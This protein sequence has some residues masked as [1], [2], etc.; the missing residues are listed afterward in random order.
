MSGKNHNLSATHL[1]GRNNSNFAVLVVMTALAFYVSYLLIR[2]FTPA[3]VWSVT[4][5]VVT[6]R[7]WQWLE[8]YVRWPNLRAG[9]AVGTVAVALLAPIVFLVYFSAGEISKTIDQWQG[10]EHSTFWQN[11]LGQN[12]RIEEAW[13]WISENFD[14]P[15]MAQQ[16]ARYLQG[17]AARIFSGL[18]YTAVQAFLTLF[19][20]YFLYRDEREVLSAVRRFSPMTSSETDQVLHRLRDTILATIYGSVVVALIQGLLGGLIFLVLGVPGAILWG[21]AM[22]LLAL[23]PYLG[24]F[25]V[26]MP[27]AVV[28]ALYGEWGKAGMLVAWG[29]CVIAMIDNLL[30]PVLVGNRLNQHTVISFIAIVGGITLF[31][32]AGIVLGPVLIEFTF[33][34]MEIWRRRMNKAATVGTA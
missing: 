1:A 33:S 13:N 11:Q 14:V 34:L 30:Y 12:P 4:L 27:A 5:A 23:V 32:A 18:A 9:I 15:A 8:R 26:W 24:T 29:V 3:L 25:V 2:P 19:V 31:G 21:V 16:T 7:F 10:E 6:K 17:G 22:G 28:L 20:L